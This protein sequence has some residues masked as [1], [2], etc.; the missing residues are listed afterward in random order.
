MNS[1]I[2]VEVYDMIDSSDPED[3]SKQ[4]LLGGYDFKMTDFIK[5]DKTQFELE[6]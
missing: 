6:H 1:I 5:M 3:L 2:A 4:N